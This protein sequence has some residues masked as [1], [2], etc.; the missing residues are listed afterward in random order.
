MTPVV[1]PGNCCLSWKSSH[2]LSSAYFLK[3][4]QAGLLCPL[5]TLKAAGKILGICELPPRFPQPMKAV[6]PQKKKA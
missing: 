4:G 6:L 5:V 3:A 2:F 1:I